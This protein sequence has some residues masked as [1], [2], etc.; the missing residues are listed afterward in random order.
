MPRT[1]VGRF[2]VPGYGELSTAH[3][4]SFEIFAVQ[5]FLLKFIA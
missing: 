4:A 1:V 3:G 2:G 5:P